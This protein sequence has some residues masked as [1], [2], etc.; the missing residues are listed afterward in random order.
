MIAAASVQDQELAIA[1]KRPGVNNPTV[2]GR[3]NLRTGVSGDRLPPLSSADAIGTAEFADFHAVDR[4]TQMPARGRKG[5]RRGKTPWILERGKV[6]PGGVL[7]DRARLGMRF[8]RR[9]IEA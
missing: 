3:S 6:G 7:L 2:A 1:A 9:G 8:A 5:D 4:Q